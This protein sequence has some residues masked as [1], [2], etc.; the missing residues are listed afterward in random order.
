MKK[1]T[2]LCLIAALTVVCTGCSSKEQPVETT[3]AEAETTLSP[4]VETIEPTTEPTEPDSI[5]GTVIVNKAG[6]IIAMLSRGKQVEI[7]DEQEEW[8]VVNTSAGPGLMEKRLVRKDGQEQPAP[9]TGYAK[10]NAVLYDGYHMEG[11]GTKL[12]TNTKF[13]VLEDLGGCYLVQTED[14][15]GYILTDSVSQYPAR[16][17]G[18]GGDSG[19][20]SSGGSSGGSGGSGSSGGQ[21]GGDISLTAFHPDDFK[22][23]LLS[24]KVMATVLAD[25]A[26][27]YAIYLNRGDIVKV[28]EYDEKTSTIYLDGIYAQLPRI[29]VRLEGDV[30]YEV[31]TGYTRWNAE[32]Y[33]NPYLLGEPTLLLKTNTEVKILEDLGYCY[34]AEIGDYIFFLRPEQ[35]SKWKATSGSGNNSDGGGN[36]GGSSDGGSSS[37]GGEW[38]PP[39]L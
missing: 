25:D 3:V 30:P 16:S 14:G 20:S 9:W 6:A 27:V 24:S 36:S 4:T 5:S 19:G 22:V 28:T 7:L 33:D 37:G 34:V 35:V 2:M 8:F 12:K 18:S 13:E 15:L 26:E 29:F 32:A 17:G 39:A 1:L 21:D 11:E 31:W 10:W 23:V 38:T